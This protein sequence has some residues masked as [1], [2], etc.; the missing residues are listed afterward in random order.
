MHQTKLIRLLSVLDTEELK[1]FQKFLHSPYHNSNKQVIPFLEY[2][3]EYHPAFDH[4]NLK[5]ETVYRKIHPD[6]KAYHEGRMNLLMSQLGQLLKQ[7]LAFEQV[8]KDEFL[9]RKYRLK[10]Y[11]EKQ[12]DDEYTKEIEKQEAALETWRKDAT[13]HLEKFLLNRGVF[14]HPA[15]PRYQ[16]G[17]PSL[18]AS[19]EH[20]DMLFVWEKMRLGAAAYNRQRILN[21]KH[22]I[23]V[24]D[25]VLMQ[26]R[27]IIE[28]SPT[29]DC[30]KD[31][32]NIQRSGNESLLLEMSKSFEKIT[33]GFSSEEQLEIFT[34][35]HN[36]NSQK[37]RQGKSEF[38]IG[39]FDLNK[40]RY[41]NESTMKAVQMNDVT[42]VN[43][44]AFGCVNYEFE[45][46]LNFINSY[47]TIV[48]ESFR[49]QEG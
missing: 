13:Y 32:L 29:L 19:L 21:E 6:G 35:L 3:A 1:S 37:I 44:V 2:I 31:I 20:L 36:I 34:Y 18:D 12:L 17:M 30:Y 45:W 42:F 26:F 41:G 4:K 25:E 22:D 5:K 40:F 10:A 28:N 14:F 46:V 33:M 23:Q 16:V 38:Y 43:M 49:G 47:K 15:T 11:R 7:F 48:R 9:Q 39:L 24:L 8:K 27:N